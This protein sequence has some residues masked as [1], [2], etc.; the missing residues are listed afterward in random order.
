MIVDVHAHLLTHSGYEHNLAK[1]AHEADV[2]KMV[3]TGGPKQY[4]Y[5]A[6]DAVLAAAERYP[7]LF[8]P[9]AYFRLGHDYPAL[10][11]QFRSQGFQGLHF[12]LP[13]R[14]YDDKSYYL[15]YAQAGQMGM[16]CLFE[17]GLLPNSG[18]DHVHDVCCG[19]MRPVCLD[20]IARAFPE[21][22]LIGTRLGSPW[23][24]EACEVARR[25]ANVYLDLSGDVLKRLPPEALARLLWWG[26]PD[27][28][29]AEG[30]PPL[31]PWKKIL[32][33]SGVHYKHLGDVRGDYET[34]MTHL[35]LSNENAT[36]VMAR[37]AIRALGLDY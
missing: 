6:N 37:N 21:L 19:R 13:Q 30:P 17:L 15:A 5:A 2:V 11:D 24:E 36:D 29:Y 7:N 12:A 23:C 33:G 22:T 27:A 26:R 34:M 1:A 14:N 3:L 25:N 4:D 10:V 20:T 32:F 9:F 31:G 35:G 28:T 8:I 16:P 18:R